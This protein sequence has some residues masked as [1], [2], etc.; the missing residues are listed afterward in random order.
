VKD[1]AF[2]SR[3]NLFA[4]LSL[5]NSLIILKCLTLK[6]IKSICISLTASIFY[7]IKFL[8]DANFKIRSSRILQKA[9][10]T[11]EN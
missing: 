11:T 10:L 5:I 1:K 2:G 8:K 3:K 7:M 9:N 4:C 6:F